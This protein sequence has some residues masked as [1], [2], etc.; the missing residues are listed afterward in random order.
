MLQ[1]ALNDSKCVIYLFLLFIGLF[2]YLSGEKDE[3]PEH[4][5]DYMENIKEKF[6]E[7]RENIK[8]IKGLNKEEMSL[9]FIEIALRCNELIKLKLK[10]NYFKLN[11]KLEV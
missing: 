11:I 2:F 1:Y 8:K 5:Q 7:N 4:V 9:I 10:E 6:A 3:H